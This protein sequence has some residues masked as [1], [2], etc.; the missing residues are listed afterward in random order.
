MAI[1][2]DELKRERERR[3]EQWG[4]WSDVSIQA[5]QKCTELTRRIDTVIARLERFVLDDVDDKTE[6]AVKAAELRA[7]RDTLRGDM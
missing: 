7:M 5:I 4:A 1:E 3:S 6:Y 2:C